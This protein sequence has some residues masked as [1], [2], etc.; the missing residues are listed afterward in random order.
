[1]NVYIFFSPVSGHCIHLRDSPQKESLLN[2]DIKTDFQTEVIPPTPPT[3]N[4]GTQTDYR[5]SEAQTD[6]Y[7]PPYFVRPGTN[8]EILL[9]KHLTWG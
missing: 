8:P 9:I 1:M 7:S 2:E 3:R 5:D 4:R 6:P